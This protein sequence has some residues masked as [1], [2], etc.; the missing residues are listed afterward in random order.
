[1]RDRNFGV[2][3]L[4]KFPLHDMEGRHF[5]ATEP[6]ADREGYVHAVATVN[7][8]KISVY[9]THLTVELISKEPERCEA[10]RLA[11]IKQLVELAHHDSCEH[12]IIAGD[13]NTLRKHDYDF[14]IDGVKAWDLIDEVYQQLFSVPFNPVALDYLATQGFEDSFNLLKIPTPT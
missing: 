6:N 2:M 3:I 9:G 10:I 5:L 11:Q 1:P 8:R 4:S 14:M 12:V 7:N 13:C